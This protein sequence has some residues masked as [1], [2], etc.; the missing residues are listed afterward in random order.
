LTYVPDSYKNVETFA[1]VRLVHYRPIY[2]ARTGT[3]PQFTHMEG[4]SDRTARFGN[5]ARQINIEC[6]LRVSWTKQLS[7]VIGEVEPLVIVTTRGYKGYQV[8]PHG[9]VH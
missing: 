3:N 4:G 1:K 2:A 5:G 7:D 6:I 9:S 8:L